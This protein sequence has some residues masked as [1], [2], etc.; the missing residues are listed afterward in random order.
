MLALAVTVVIHLTQVLA[1]TLSAPSDVALGI[2]ALIG[3]LL[4]EAILRRAMHRKL[5]IL[6]V[7]PVSWLWVWIP[8]C[9][10]VMVFQPLKLAPLR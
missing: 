2:D 8:L 7:W 10:F 4:A 5:V 6:R 1:I 9:L 3:G